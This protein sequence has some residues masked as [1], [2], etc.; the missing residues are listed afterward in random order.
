MAREKTKRPSA[1]AEVGGGVPGADEGR[2]AWVP[3]DSQM[4]GGS[5]SDNTDGND[6]R[7]AANQTDAR[8][9]ADQTDATAD[10]TDATDAA[11]KTDETAD[12]TDAT[13]KHMY[14][15]RS[16]FFKKVYPSVESD[17][18]SL[19]TAPTGTQPLR[20][21]QT[22][23]RN[24][25]VLAVNHKTISCC[26]AGYAADSWCVTPMTVVRV[27]DPGFSKAPFAKNMDKKKM[28]EAKPLCELEGDGGLRMYSFKKAPMAKGDRVDDMSFSIS[29]G[30]TFNT[31]M[32][33]SKYKEMRRLDPDQQSLPDADSAAGT[34]IPAYSL[35]EVTVA[36]KNSES[37]E[38]KGSLVNIMKV[39]RVPD[40][41]TLHSVAGVLGRLPSNLNDALLKTAA[42]AL[43]SP[44][45]T[46]D[47]QRDKVAFFKPEC[48]PDTCVESVELL[49]DG[50]TSRF[51][52][53]SAWSN[54][55]CENINSVDV[56]EAMLLRMC[57]ATNVDHA[58]SLLSIAFAMKA[59]SL[60]VTHNAFIARGGAS[61]LRG[62]PLINVS[63]LLAAV[64]FD[65]SSL[66]LAG[67]TSGSTVHLFETGC[68]YADGTD[69]T[70]EIQIGV[71]VEAA[72][73]TPSDV[74]PAQDFPLLLPG[75]TSSK[76]YMCTA[77]LKENTNPNNPKD[78]VPGVLRF[79]IDASTRNATA[80]VMRRAKRKLTSM[81]WS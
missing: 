67:N 76:T 26:E 46:K 12:K 25:V 39:R 64:K 57:N 60:F 2:A 81:Q 37:A 10:K 45:V 3:E 17:F 70:Q 40:D 31:F 13:A 29:P 73:G 18:A 43:A 44:C 22:S 62:V 52:R 54:E 36:P 42:K 8:D 50:E 53:L 16:T 55:L 28:S 5:D 32:D 74:C 65:S 33:L 68:Q 80:S 15:S 20:G 77:S 56:S 58:V 9:A 63:K 21:L 59:V 7:D 30:D 47:L 23:S 51:V 69:G 41:V 11:D 34:S 79:G 38:F 6:A 66:D 27:Q 61:P 14:P 35:I 78:G 49:E 1:S 72:T 4:M 19:R 75:F 48:A 24:A 71:D